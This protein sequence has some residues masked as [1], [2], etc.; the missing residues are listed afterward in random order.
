MTDGMPVFP[1]PLESDAPRRPR[2]VVLGL[3]AVVLI[4]SATAW[5]RART[6]EDR[7]TPAL[8][9]PRVVDPD[10]RAPEGVRIRTR[11]V[12]AT[13]ERG[14]ARRATL[15]LRDFGFDVVDYDTQRGQAQRETEIRSHDGTNDW[16]TRVQRALGVGRVTAT[17]DS[18]RYL[19]VTVILG[20]DW[21]PPPEPFRP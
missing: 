5:W 1:P 13:G 15:H 21:Q 16:A 17:P 10:A 2:R 14:L 12:N 8:A 9:V 18:L 6:A 19:D 3:F 20:R 4:G 11:V 7:A